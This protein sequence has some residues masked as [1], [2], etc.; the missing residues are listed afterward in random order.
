MKD[1]E[2]FE[3]DVPDDPLYAAIEG[4]KIEDDEISKLKLK[5]C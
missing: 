2:D 4:P 5:I 1:D 3:V